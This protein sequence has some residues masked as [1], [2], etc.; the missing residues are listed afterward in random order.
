MKIGLLVEY[1]KS[2]VV[3]KKVGGTKMGSLVCFRVSGRFFL[4]WSGSGVPGM[5]W[6]SVVQVDYVEQMNRKVDRKRLKNY[7]L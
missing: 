6:T 7:P 3:P 1:K 4:F 2:P 5:F